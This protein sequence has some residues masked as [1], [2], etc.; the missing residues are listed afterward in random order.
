MSLTRRRAGILSQ[1]RQLDVFVRETSDALR[2]N[3][4][5]DCETAIYQLEGALNAH[6]AVEEGVIFPTLLGLRPDLSDWVAESEREHE[7]LR[8]QLDRLSRVIIA[9]D[10]S[11]A[12]LV[13]EEFEASLR[14]HELTEERVLRNAQQ[15]LSN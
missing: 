11:T 12:R 14:S 6:F 13:H 15:Q 1:H 4:Q 10:L 7:G 9:S 5:R 2:R 8:Q 3:C